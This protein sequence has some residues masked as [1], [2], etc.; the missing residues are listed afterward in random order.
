MGSASFL[1]DLISHLLDP[2]LTEEEKQATFEGV[3]VSDSYSGPHIS[4]PL[5]VSD[6]NT[7]L[8][9]FKAQQVTTPPPNVM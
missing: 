3:E 5:T 7:W 4:F 9:V 1:S 2:A 6:T 8:S